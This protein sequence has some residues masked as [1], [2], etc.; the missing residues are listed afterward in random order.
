M[1]PAKVGFAE[2]LRPGRRTASIT[3][4]PRRT[5]SARPRSM[6]A[7]SIDRRIV[8]FG[9]HRR[10]RSAVE[11]LT[12]ATSGSPNTAQGM[13]GRRPMGGN[14]RSAMRWT[15]RRPS[16]FAACVWWEPGVT[17]PTAHIP[18]CD[19]RPHQSLCSLGHH[20]T[21][22]H[23]AGEHEAHHQNRERRDECH[24][25]EFGQPA[26]EGGDRCSGQDEG[27]GAR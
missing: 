27:D 5:P 11:S 22:S 12:Q 4:S 14:D 8:A 26:V 21:S 24:W 17:S 15:K 2:T 13:S 10:T 18:R 20:L 3:T 9:C 1:A 19:V 23:E 7:R 25:F 6:S 16:A